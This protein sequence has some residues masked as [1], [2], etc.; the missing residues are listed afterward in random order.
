MKIYFFADIDLFD[1]YMANWLIDYNTIIP[2]LYNHFECH[3]LW[4][5]T[6]ALQKYH[7]FIY[8]IIVM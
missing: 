3:M 4:T 1:Q 7:F 5:N 6:L 8:N 2:H